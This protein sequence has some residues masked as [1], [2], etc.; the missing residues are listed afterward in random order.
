[1]SAAAVQ[2]L[3][4][5]GINF[6]H[7]D[8]LAMVQ[9]QQ[10]REALVAE[11]E[12]S[13][14]IQTTSPDPVAPT[15]TPQEPRRKYAGKYDSIE[16]FE[17]GYWNSAQEAMRMAAELKA[18][19]ELLAAQQR[20]NPA[21]RAEARVEYVEELRDAAIP[22][23][24]LDKLVTERATNIAKQAVRDV[25]EPIARGTQA[26]NDLIK[27]YPNYEQVEK[28]LDE[29]LSANPAINDEYQQLMNAG[30]EKLAF[31][32]AYLNFEHANPA[33]TI[34]DA[35]GQEQAVARATGALIS[36]NTVGAREVSNSF[37][38]K[39]KAA[40]ERF[41]IDRDERALA[42]VALMGLHPDMA[43]P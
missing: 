25:F 24:A 38:N 17:E 16:K 19:R 28:G 34:A 33:K 11:A 43:T 3:V 12:Q 41:A 42:A 22:V 29:F 31:K 15:A 35:S 7:P 39:L 9:E 18:T 8:V 2:E 21:E 36:G 30:Q 13:A 20:V 4:N 32:Y 26:R 27:T 10:G 14:P 5:A 37:E 40:Q 1:M 6:T 23:E